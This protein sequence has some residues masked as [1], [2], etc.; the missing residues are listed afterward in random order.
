M[1]LLGEDVAQRL[2]DVP[3]SF[4]IAVMGARNLRARDATASLR[5]LRRAVSLNADD[6]PTGPQAQLADQMPFY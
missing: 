2:E 1:K 6:T 5:R 3:A 4:Q